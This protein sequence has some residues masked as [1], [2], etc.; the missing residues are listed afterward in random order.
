MVVVSSTAVIATTWILACFI[1]TQAAIAGAI[2][3]TVACVGAVGIYLILRMTE[4]RPS[5]SDR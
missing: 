5:R 2:V 1:G 3:M 4:D